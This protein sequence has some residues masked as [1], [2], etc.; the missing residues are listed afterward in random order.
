MNVDLM[1][2]NPSDTER[3][4]D[5]RSKHFP[6]TAKKAGLRRLASS[7]GRRG[8]EIAQEISAGGGPIILA[9]RS[10]FPCALREGYSRDG[11]VGGT[12]IQ[13]NLGNPN[14]LGLASVRIPENSDYPVK[15]S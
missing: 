12:P 1:N 15:N 6:L 2:V 7:E 4:G 3:D 13:W 8:S 14:K 5:G 10:P 11:V 9:N